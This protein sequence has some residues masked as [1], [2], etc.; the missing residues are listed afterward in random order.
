MI[1][2]FTRAVTFALYQFTIAL[3]IIMLPVAILTQRLGLT[4]PV[5]RVVQAVDTLHRGSQ[6]TTS[7]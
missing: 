5:H 1:D 7:R 3:G 4:L 6:S 2:R